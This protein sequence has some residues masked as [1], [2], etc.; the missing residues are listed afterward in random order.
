[1]KEEVFSGTW[2]MSR[3]WLRLEAAVSQGPDGLTSVA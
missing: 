2:G 3:N 1:M